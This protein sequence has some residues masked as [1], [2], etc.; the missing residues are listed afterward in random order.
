MNKKTNSHVHVIIIRD[1]TLTV[2]LVVMHIKFFHLQ[3]I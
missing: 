2:T 3:A 1:S